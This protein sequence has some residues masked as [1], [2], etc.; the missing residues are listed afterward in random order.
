MQTFSTRSYPQY[1]VIAEAEDW[2]DYHEARNRGPSATFLGDLD[3]EGNDFEHNDR[4]GAGETGWEDASNTYWYNNA[5]AD[6]RGWGGSKYYFEHRNGAGLDE[7][8]GFRKWLSF[9]HNLDDPATAFNEKGTCRNSYFRSLD[10]VVKGL[11]IPVEA[12]SHLQ[13]GELDPLFG[14]YEGDMAAYVRDVLGPKLDDPDLKVFLG[15]GGCSQSGLPATHLMILQIECPISIDPSGDCGDRSAAEAQAA[16]WGIVPVEPGSSETDA[17][18]RVSHI[19]LFDD[20]R[21]ATHLGVPSFSTEPEDGAL[22]NL[23]VQ[24]DF[25]RSDQA[26][27]GRYELGASPWRIRTDSSFDRGCAETDMYFEGELPGW[28]QAPL[29]AKLDPARGEILAVAEAAAALNPAAPAPGGPMTCQLILLDGERVVAFAEFDEAGSRVAAGGTLGPDGL[30]QAPERIAE[31]SAAEL[32]TLDPT[33]SEFPRFVLRVGPSGIRLLEASPGDYTPNR[34][35]LLDAYTVLA[36]LGA[37]AP[38]GPVDAVRFAAAGGEG[39]LLAAVDGFAVLSDL[40]A[41]APKGDFIRGDTNDDAKVDISDGIFLL[42]HLFL[43]GE[44]WVCEEGADVNDDGRAD[45]SDAIYAFNFLFLGGPEVP[46]PHPE[47]GPDPNGEVCPA[48][49]CNAR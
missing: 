1:G 32:P 25:W 42:N 40:P 36:E 3:A 28:F 33:A 47:C 35:E 49:R 10:A 22:R 13:D 4:A 37:P 48:S 8:Q 6:Q 39:R 18:Y 45:L 43:G 2:T 15:S 46:P 12:I 16:Y 9:Q 44:R 31:G 38:A 21:T 17:V 7:I 27:L 24:D 29:A 26:K 41:P 30:A 20:E 23:W 11:L 5:V 14:W 19:L 34:Y